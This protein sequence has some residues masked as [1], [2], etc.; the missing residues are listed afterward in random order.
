MGRYGHQDLT[1]SAQI[2]PKQV[3]TIVMITMMTM[4]MMTR[5]KKVRLHH[6]KTIKLHIIEGLGNKYD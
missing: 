3:G 5:E 4:S 2:I 1:I 6:T